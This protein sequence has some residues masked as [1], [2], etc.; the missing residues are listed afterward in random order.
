[1]KLLDE[2]YPF[3]SR[4]QFAEWIGGGDGT[5]G[6][7]M[8]LGVA[9]GAIFLFFYLTRETSSWWFLAALASLGFVAIFAVWRLMEW[10]RRVRRRANPPVRALDLD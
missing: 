9:V 4:T 7:L 1:M 6:R 2:I 3:R 8:R 10:R 5:M